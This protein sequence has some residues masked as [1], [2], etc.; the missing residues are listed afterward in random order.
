MGPSLS[1]RLI[2]LFQLYF[3]RPTKPCFHHPAVWRSCI[4]IIL[5]K[6]NK[7]NK[8]DPKSY[9]IISLLNCLGKVLEKLYATRL[10]Y[11]ANTTELLHGSQL[12][13]RK[14]RSAIDAA[15]LLTQY[16]EEQRQPGKVANNTITTTIF[17]HIKG[18]FDY[19]TKEKLIVSERLCLPRPLISWVRTF[20]TNRSV[21][22]AFS[23]QIQQQPTSL[24]IGTPQGSLISPILFLIYIRDIVAEKGFQLSYIDNYSISVSSTSA[25]KNCKVLEKTVDS[26]K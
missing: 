17:L 5:P 26:L 13:G 18:G 3:A 14:Q 19:V 20:L 21:Q 15:L 22:L 8:S 2:T 23:G 11:L 12:G 10:N 25:R 16:I 7:T 9:R 4:G 24:T 6:P 1:K